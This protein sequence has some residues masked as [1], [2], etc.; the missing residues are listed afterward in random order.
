MRERASFQAESAVEGIA[1]LGISPRI[2]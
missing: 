2:G 1:R